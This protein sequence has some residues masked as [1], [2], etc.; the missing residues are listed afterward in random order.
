MWTTLPRNCPFWS[1][2]G[3]LGPGCSPYSFGFTGLV[4][5]GHYRAHIGQLAVPSWLGPPCVFQTAPPP[6]FGLPAVAWSCRAFC[7]SSFAFSGSLPLRRLA[8]ARPVAQLL[9]RP[10]QLLLCWLVSLVLLRLPPRMLRAPSNGSVE[11][12]RLFRKFAFRI[13]SCR[14][15][16]RFCGQPNVVRCS[17]SCTN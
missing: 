3:W 5:P 12:T 15:L 9:H 7:F 8:Q 1:Y 6:F 17:L 11:L 16:L 4:D 13:I 14:L 2:F 10:R